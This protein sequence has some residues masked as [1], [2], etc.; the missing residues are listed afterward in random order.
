MKHVN[1]P[2]F[3]PQLG[4]PHQC[5]YCNQKTISAQTSIPNE[6]QVREQIS[7]CFKSIG[8]KVDEVEIAYFGGSFTSLPM[9]R[10]KTYLEAARPFLKHPKFCG[11]R[12]SARPDCIDEEE[13][14]F[15]KTFGVKTIELG[16]QSFADVVLKASGRLYSSIQAMDAC[17]MVKS[18]G[19]RL[20]VQVMSGLPEDNYRFAIQTA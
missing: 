11:V 7:R 4:C 12:I 5:I 2:I 9:G 16:I 14:H 8:P 3:I 10:Q 15:L 19:F 6:K 20:G 18:K 17:H 1:I 13:L